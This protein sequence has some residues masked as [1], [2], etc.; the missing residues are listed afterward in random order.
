MTNKSIL[1]G[2]RINVLLSREAAQ[3]SYRIRSSRK[4]AGLTPS[5]KIYHISRRRTLALK[6]PYISLV[7]FGPH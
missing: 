6:G 1:M 7:H 5:P 3:Q 2:W 4:S